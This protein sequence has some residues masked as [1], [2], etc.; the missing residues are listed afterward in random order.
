MVRYL[1]VKAFLKMREK[2]IN[3]YIKCIENPAKISIHKYI[4]QQCKN[5]KVCFFFNKINET[6]QLKFPTYSELSENG[7]LTEIFPNK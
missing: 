6:I 7:I 2:K 4:C 1:L 3:S 5:R